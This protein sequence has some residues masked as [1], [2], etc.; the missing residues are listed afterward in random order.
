MGSGNGD[1]KQMKKPY[2][3]LLI[4]GILSGALYLAL[5]LYEREIME[6]FSRSD[7]FYPALPVV[8]ALVFSFVHGAFASCFW[9]IVGVTARPKSG[10]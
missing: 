7:G 5:Y 8:T 1:R 9:D 2:A 4:S 10:G 6:S 3:G